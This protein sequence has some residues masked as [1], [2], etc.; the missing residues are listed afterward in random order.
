MDFSKLGDPGQGRVSALGP[1]LSTDAGDPAVAPSSAGVL[2]TPRRPK[3]AAPGG[4]RGAQLGGNCRARRYRVPEKASLR[5]PQSLPVLHE[6]TTGCPSVADTPR[7]DQ[8]ADEPMARDASQDVNE[9]RAGVQDLQEALSLLQGLQASSDETGST[10]WAEGDLVLLT[11]GVGRGSQ[12]VITEV[13][14][15]HCT[16]ICLDR[17]GSCG[18]DQ[19]WPSIA[20]MELL[21]S[22]LRLGTTVFIKGLRKE[23]LRHLNGAKGIIVR[24]KRHGHP[25]FVTPRG[26]VMPVLHAV[27]RLE[28]PTADGLRT[29]LLE[30][31][32]VSQTP[33]EETANKV[34]EKGE[35]ES[36][37]ST[38]DEQMSN[39]GSV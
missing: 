15:S 2:A 27:V 12:A 18:I 11:E 22:N 37:S 20:Q 6:Q 35:S 28:R 29:V 8:S 13:A 9:A 23:G 7:T 21:N 3:Q 26:Q 10:A 39:E 30:A 36:C 5:S 1:L 25:V 19:V 24:H 17:S 34:G 33:P 38:C 4:R 14:D 32:C 31:R 16:A